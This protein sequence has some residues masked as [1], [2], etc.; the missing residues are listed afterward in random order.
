MKNSNT[1]KIVVAIGLA[2]IYATALA[3]ALLPHGAKESAV[4]QSPP[5]ANSGQSVIEP[6][7][8]PV[9]VPEAA[10]TLAVT[11]PEVQSP[12]RESQTSSRGT[13]QIVANV[14]ASSR[15]E[16]EIG[17]ASAARNNVGTADVIVA[18][19]TSQLAADVPDGNADVTTPEG[20]AEQAALESSPQ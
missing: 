13:E 20:E 8:A 17:M 3:A 15:N 5:V 7:A 14:A 6:E 4:V 2:A 16:S 19:A 11:K 9:I 10:D 1:P 18:E 12:R